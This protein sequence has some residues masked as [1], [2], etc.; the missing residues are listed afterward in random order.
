MLGYARV[1]SGMLGYCLS[2]AWVIPNEY[3]W[4][5]LG[6]AWV[7]GMLGY[8]SGI[9][10]LLGYNRLHEAALSKNSLGQRVLDCG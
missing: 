10:R 3:A 1:C 5:L 6:Y 2:I 9:A 7:M 4:L 8:Y